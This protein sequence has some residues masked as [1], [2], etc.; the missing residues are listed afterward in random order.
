MNYGLFYIM[1]IKIYPSRLESEPLETH[2]I[3]A[4]I[5]VRNWLASVDYDVDRE[6][7]AITVTINGVR[8][9]CSRWSSVDINPDDDAAVYVEA[10][11]TGVI[12][13]IAAVLSIASIVMALTNKPKTPKSQ[14]QGRS[15]EDVG[16]FANTVNWGDSIPEIAGAPITFPDYIAPPRRHFAGR[17]EQW[18][19]SLL[20][21]GRGEYQTDLSQVFVGDTAA[22]SLGDNFEVRFFGPNDDIPAPYNE[23]W[24]TPE[25]VGFTTLGGSGMTMGVSSTISGIWQ[26]PFSFLGASI[27]SASAVPDEWESGMFVRVEAEHPLVFDGD[28]IQS[29]LL[30]SLEIEV[31]DDIELT[32]ERSGVYVIAEIVPAAGSDNTKYIVD[33]ANFGVG[34]EVASAG[35]DGLTYTITATDE[36]TITVA[37][38]D[39]AFWSGFPSSVSN[40]TSYVAIDSGSQEVGWLGPF[41]AVPVGKLADATEVDIALPSGLIRY[42]SKGRIKYQTI[43]GVIQWRYLGDSAWNTVPFSNTEAT[44]DHIGFTYRISHDAGRVEVRVKSNRAPSVNASEADK[45]Q[46]VG[47]RSRIIGAPTRYEGMTLMHVR[48]RSGDK[49]SGQVENKI[50]LR[51][52]RVLPTVQ[53]PEVS[54]PTR[55]I[56]PFFIHMMDSVGYGRDM[57]DMPHLEQL[58]GI[59]IAR[60]DTFDLSVNSNSTLKTV[61]NYCLGAGFAEMTLRN[62][63]ISA[64]REVL[65][66]GY[67]SRVYSAQEMTK[68][69]LES[70]TSVM[71]DDVDGV[72]V[73]YVDYLSGR[74]TTESYRLEGDEGRRVETIKAVGVSG[75]VQA[76]RIAARHRRKLAYQRTVFKGGTELAAMNSYY[77]DYVGLQDGIPEYGQSAFILAV[78]GLNITVSEPVQAVGGDM[79]MIFRRPDGRSTDPVSVTAANGHV[80]TVDSVPA[81]AEVSTDP[82]APTVVYFGAVNNVMHQALITAVRP[83]ANGTVEFQAKIMDPRIYEDDGE[84]PLPISWILRMGELELWLDADDSD[85]ISTGNAGGV[86]TW[87]DRSPQKND[88]TQPDAKSRPVVTG[89]ALL[90]QT[91]TFERRY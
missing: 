81:N 20:C 77:M 30:D 8:I 64:A 46:W 35:L 91:I 14:K 47:L 40:A 67:P 42:N 3:S 25:E 38:A 63:K 87:R 34:T 29:E 6:R 61:S 7:H 18:V 31:G 66:T 55:D 21:V 13:T 69:L 83:S 37:V 9:E 60:G 85:T 76:R 27:S 23:W 15:L 71:P 70:T 68:P 53:D 51:A 52:M 4:P 33:G 86:T 36:Q 88:A 73:E 54:E 65:Q 58:H 89:D 84:D 5:S 16:T 10:S 80:V 82:N 62:G 1:T 78:D 90:S 11:A 79:I 56:I 50:G 32:G 75:R 22:P 28:S 59:Y 19:E 24:H 74:T 49:V 57:L 41:T 48:M 17:R 26:G 43:G 2:E 45:Q 72:D 39:V 12:A 44:P